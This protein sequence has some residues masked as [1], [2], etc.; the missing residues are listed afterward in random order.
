M[1]AQF[2][3]RDLRQHFCSPQTLSA[4]PRGWKMLAQFPNHVVRKNKLCMLRMHNPMQFW[5]QVINWTANVSSYHALTTIFGVFY[6]G[7]WEFC[8]DRRWPPHIQK[9]QLLWN[10]CVLAN[11]KFPRIPRIHQ[12]PPA[13]PQNSTLQIFLEIFDP[14]T[15]TSVEQSFLDSECI[16]NQRC[17]GTMETTGIFN[18]SNWY[19]SRLPRSS[20][21]SGKWLEGEQQKKSGSSKM[22]ADFA[23]SATTGGRMDK[24]S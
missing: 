18:P 7:I 24:R 1:L 14:R 19:I 22:G 9:S 2:A 10:L 4:V 23:N 16:Y 5:I 17:Y 6:Y 15:S 20:D 21:C 11:T 8:T 12:V 3:W 13:T